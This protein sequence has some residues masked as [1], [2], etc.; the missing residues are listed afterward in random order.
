MKL[1]N[2]KVGRFHFG[3]D[4]AATIVID[5]SEFRDAH[6]PRSPVEQ[7]GAERFFKLENLLAH[8]CPGYTK[9]VCR[10]REATAIHDMDENLHRAEPVHIGKSLIV[11]ELRT[12]MSHFMRFSKPLFASIVRAPARSVNAKPSEE[13]DKKMKALTGLVIGAIALAA[14]SAFA[15]ASAQ[16]MSEKLMME[17]KAK[18]QDAEAAAAIHKRRMAMRMLGGQMKVVADYMKDGKGSPQDIAAAGTKIA[19]IAKEIP[20]LFPKGTGLDK[21]PGGTGAKTAIWEKMEDFKRA[22]MALEKHA[23]ELTKVASAT[24]ASKATIGAAFGPVGKIG[25]G[26]CHQGYRE[27]LN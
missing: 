3:K 24:D 13:D 19:S 20:G 7:P 27:K 6:P 23:A 8:R 11:N 18:V 22:A 25:C 2:Q 9:T 17:I 14:T 1:V 10:R 4:A 5:M 16:G 15:P 21:H 26:G 12:M